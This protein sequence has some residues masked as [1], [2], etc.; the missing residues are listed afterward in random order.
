MTRA[1]S[2]S[3]PTT[4]LAWLPAEIGKSSS[5][6]RLRRGQARFRQG[7]SVVGIFEVEQGSVRLVRN[8]EDDREVILHTARPGELFA[9]AA[10]FSSHYHCDAIAATAARVR[11]YPKPA[12]LNA[13]RRDPPLAERFMALL[14]RQVQALRAALT[15]RNIR[16]APRRLLA[17]LSL[18]V[19][20]DRKTIR[21]GGSLKDLAAEIGLTH[22]ALYRALARL[23][24]EGALSRGKNLIVLQRP[25]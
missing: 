12:L 20:A 1:R 8:T 7:D 2:T 23:E 11:L 9:E 21:L 5:T 15:Q 4:A 18:K 17:H 22:E 6:R 10:L 19:E 13:L 25:V 16:S 14:A 24:S 3:Q